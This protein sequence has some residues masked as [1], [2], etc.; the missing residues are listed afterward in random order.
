[1][2]ITKAQIE[3][4]EKILIDNGIEPDEASIVLESIGFALLNKDIY[5]HGYRAHNIQWDR[6]DE[7]GE[8]VEADLPSDVVVTLDDLR[9]PDNATDQEIEDELA[10]YL[11]DNFGFCHNGFFFEK[12]DYRD[13]DPEFQEISY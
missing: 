6:T 12:A 13:E 4:A 9:L 7:D 2:N 1:M 11:T 10:I 5:V 8:H 3:A